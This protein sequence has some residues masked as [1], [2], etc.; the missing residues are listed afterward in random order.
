MISIAKDPHVYQSTHSRMK[1]T[2][3]NQK[4]I[5]LHTTGNDL[6]LWRNDL[7]HCSQKLKFLLPWLE[8]R[9]VIDNAVFLLRPLIGALRNLSLFICNRS[10]SVAVPGPE[11]LMGGRVYCDLQFS[12]QRKAWPQE[13]E[14]LGHVSSILR[15]PPDR[16]REKENWREEGVRE[17]WG[18]RDRK[19]EQERA[20]ELWRSD[21]TSRCVCFSQLEV[22]I[23]FP[24]QEVYLP[25]ICPL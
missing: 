10:F 18:K 7:N 14:W 21:S 20:K 12:L 17:R 16:Q 5:V 9:D 3:F 1:M 11:P 22:D 25:G 8:N 23:A 6:R 19:Q 24:G 13:H 4:T 15:N 2:S